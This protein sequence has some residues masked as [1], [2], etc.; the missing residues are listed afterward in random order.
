M[1]PTLIFY[2]EQDRIVSVE[3]IRLFDV[4]QPEN[5]MYEKTLMMTEHFL[6]KSGYL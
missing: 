5:G 6:R 3:S 4:K 1:P 2:G